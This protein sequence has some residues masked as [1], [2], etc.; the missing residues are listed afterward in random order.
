MRSCSSSPFFYPCDLGRCLSEPLLWTFCLGGLLDFPLTHCFVNRS[1]LCPS[2]PPSWLLLSYLKTV[3]GKQPFVYQWFKVTM[4]WEKATCTCT[5]GCHAPHGRQVITIP[6]FGN[7]LSFRTS[8]SSQWSC[9]HDLWPSFCQF[10]AIATHW[11]GWIYF[12]TTTVK[13]VIKL[14]L[15]WLTTAMTHDGN[16]GSNHGCKLRTI[17]D[18]T[19]LEPLNVPS[20]AL[21]WRSLVAL[22][23]T[24]SNLSLSFLN[25]DAQNWTPNRV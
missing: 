13:M 12:I 1:H 23:G 10:L 22:I 4:P 21:E 8:H 2:R 19:S 9:D 24:C 15:T 18:Q 17:A 20:G 25:W 6:T 14:S 11:G 16:S 7:R 5:Y 3:M